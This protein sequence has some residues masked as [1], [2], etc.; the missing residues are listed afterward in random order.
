[1]SGLPPHP[2]V[3]QGW[4]PY[5][6]TVAGQARTT[7]QRA[8]EMLGY[9]AVNLRAHE[10]TRHA[11]IDDLMAMAAFAD[12]LGAEIHAI[13]EHELRV[14]QA[15]RVELARLRRRNAATALLLE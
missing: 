3:P 15:R 9:D 1:M 10:W 6:D 11:R 4:V 14:E 12:S 13:H 2:W 7:I 8:V 5:S